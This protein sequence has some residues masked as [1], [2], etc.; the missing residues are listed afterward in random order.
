M[1]LGEAWWLARAWNC[2]ADVAVES[3]EAMARVSWCC[4]PLFK[5]NTCVLTSDLIYRL[6]PWGA[7]DDLRHMEQ[8][9]VLFN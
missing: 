7:Y 6:E 2:R 9:I 5:C 1:D 4:C 3:L 8:V